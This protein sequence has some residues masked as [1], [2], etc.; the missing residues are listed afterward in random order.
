VR[1]YGTIDEWINHDPNAFLVNDK[2]V[3][4]GMCLFDFKKHDKP[5][6]ATYYSN[7]PDG[8]VRFFL[9]GCPYE[10]KGEFVYS[11]CSMTYA[12]SGGSQVL[13][14]SQAQDSNWYKLED[15]NELSKNIR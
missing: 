4:H 9:G 14:V 11:C 1:T 12:G 2:Y 6:P 8:A 10:C 3:P 13:S 5:F 15:L 7:L